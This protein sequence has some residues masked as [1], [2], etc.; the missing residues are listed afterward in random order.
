MK[1][2]P[3]LV[4]HMGHAKTGSTAIQKTLAA[5]RTWL[6]KNGILYPETAI[7]PHNH[8][9]LM[10]AIFSDKLGGGLGIRM[11]ATPNEILKRSELEWSSVYEQINNYKPKKIILSAEGWFKPLNDVS[12]QRILEK[13]LYISDQPPIVFA[14]IRSPSSFYLSNTQQSLRG[15]RGLEEPKSFRRLEAI[16]SFENGLNVRVNLRAFENERLYKGDVIADFSEWLGLSEISQQYSIGRFN[17][18]VSAEAMSLL[19]NFGPRNPPSTWHELT[20]QRKLT[21]IVRSVDEEVDNPTRPKLHAHVASYID[22]L[23]NDFTDLYDNYSLFFSD[24]DY[25]SLRRSCKV[26]KPEISSIEDICEINLD[27]RNFMEK[28]VKERFGWPDLTGPA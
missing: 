25:I 5:A 7:I 9:V 28:I 10:P 16:K 20:K 19:L 13:S 8:R 1:R 12:A 18:S 17:E 23:N 11:G 24:I 15:G 14:Y 21:K 4:L 26:K 2:K 22:F 27:R 6:R 3:S